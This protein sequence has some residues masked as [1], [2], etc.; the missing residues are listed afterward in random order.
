MNKAF[1]LLMLLVVS[2]SH[3]DTTKNENQFE[4][5]LKS[6][7]LNNSFAFIYDGQKHYFVQDKFSKFSCGHYLGFVDG[8]ERYDFAGSLV[9]EMNE[10]FEPL[11]S[12]E[13]RIS[14]MMRLI[15]DTDS[16]KDFKRCSA[17]K[18][19]SQY[20]LIFSP[21]MVFFEKNQGQKNWDKL[22]LGM[23][24]KEVKALMHVKNFEIREEIGH[25]Y[26]YLDQ[27][28]HRI[29][30]YFVKD[31]LYAWLRGSKPKD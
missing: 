21:L 24:F 9:H 22:R 29:V 5:S 15:S 16:K 26:L 18:R 28:K 11:K 30:L 7:N 27:A 3:N 12:P 14:Q 4:Q 6:L 2:C 20:A 13:Q 10:K 31:H 19:K 8:K 1:L 17:D 23:S 25:E